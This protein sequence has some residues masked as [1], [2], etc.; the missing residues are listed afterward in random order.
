MW[1]WITAIVVALGLFGFFGYQ[2]VISKA[3]D[4]L[5]DQIA[6]QVNEEDM[7]Q[8]MDDPIIQ[9]IIA[10]VD[11]SNTED[12]P[13]Q[14]KE[15]AVKTVLKEFSMSEMTDV[16]TKAQRGELNMAEVEALL[17]ERLTDEEIEALKIIAIKE[18]QARQ[19]Q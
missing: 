15:D 7:N 2:F 12:L 18:M 6:N 17:Q 13:F 8:F 19:S 3:S 16:A 5:V 4:V 11:T 10:N 1:K 14:T 9:R